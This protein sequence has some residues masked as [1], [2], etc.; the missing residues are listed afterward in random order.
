VALALALTVFGLSP[1]FAAA[2]TAPYFE[3]FDTSSPKAVPANFVET[4]DS[5]WTL[6]PGIYQGNAQASGG[7][8]AVGSSINLTNVVANN[9]TVKTTFTFQTNGGF[10]FRTADLGLVALAD[11]PDVTAGG[12]RLRYY[13]SGLGDVYQKLFLER[14]TGSSIGNVSSKTLASPATGDR[15]TMT[16]HGAYIDG[17]L[18]LTGTLNNG[19]R[20]IS[21]QIS[22]PA[23]LIGTNFGFRQQASVSSPHSSSVTGNYDDFSAQLE[24]KPVKFGNIATRLSV[25]T[26]NEVAIA[27]FIV[28]GN[29]PKRV[30]FLGSGFGFPAP[31]LGDPTVELRKADGSLLAF[32]DN[33]EDTQRAEIYATGLDPFG[34]ASAALIAV[35]NPGAYTVILRGKNETTGTGLLEVYDLEPN[36][37]SKL[38]NISTRGR[39]GTG[40]NAMIA[41]VIVTG[42]SKARVIVR[43]IGPSLAAAGIAGPLGDPTLELRD[44]N[45]TLVRSND[46]WRESQEAEIATSLQPTNEADAAIVADLLPTNYTAIVRGKTTQPESPWSRSII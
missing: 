18:F 37:N 2:A 21:V 24:T 15:F 11:N 31:G 9:F 33:W 7:S 1:T 14:A 41:G 35:L 25:G 20:T 12:Y 29:A 32:N 46:N 22:D 39:V 13:A 30:L 27:G 28:T 8:V 45:G 23:P 36:V 43:A 5:A 16:L 34:S 3:G 38:G 19:S 42:D 17:S 4:P 26:G 10:D 40:D 6:Y 44:R